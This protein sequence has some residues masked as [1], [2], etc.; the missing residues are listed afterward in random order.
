MSRTV[1]RLFLNIILSSAA[2]AQ[3][4]TAAATKMPSEETIN[5]FMH[6]MFG[7]EPGV[8]WQIVSV[9]P[10][11]AEGLAEV[12][13]V[14]STPQGQQS[15]KIYVTP[16]GKHAVVGEILPFGARPFDVA[17]T[18]L[19]KGINGPS[20]GPATAPVT[21]V[22]FSDLQC[23]HCKDAEPILDKLMGEEK[24]ARL[25]YQN[26]PL[27]S[28][29]WAQ[30]AAAYADC[31]GRSNSDAFWKF[32]ASVFESQTEINAANAEEKLTALADKAGV[33]GS[34][35]A[36][37]STKPDTTSRIEH[38]LALGKSVDVN[39]TPTVFVNG[40]KI[41]SVTGIPYEILK[42]IVDFAASDNKTAAK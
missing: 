34:D 35:M 3:T 20:R 42:K 31:V 19:Q 18:E 17:S 39:S 2:F 1:T 29:D 21:I 16:D 36:A 37:C 22:E 11:E 12:D 38:S 28:H 14:M 23:P 24:K 10:S 13:L 25:V 33:K 15:N 7:Y 40:R 26:F 5:G 27:P 32:I 41:G 9:K 6:Q 8:K 4:H 30:K